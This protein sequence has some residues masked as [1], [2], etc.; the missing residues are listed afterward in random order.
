MAGAW[1]FGAEK[2]LVLAAGV[3]AP[4]MALMSYPLAL[5]DGSPSPSRYSLVTLD[6]SLLVIPGVSAGIG[7]LAYAGIPVTHRD[8]NQS[9]TFVTG[10]DQTGEAG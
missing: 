10:H 6:G 2:Q 9:V 5:E 7:G 8:V 4:Q 3:L 1:A